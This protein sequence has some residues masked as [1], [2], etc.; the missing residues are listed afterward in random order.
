MTADP[1]A[2]AAKLTPA[3]RKALMQGRGHDATL[4]DLGNMGLLDEAELPALDE[5]PEALGTCTLS[6]LGLRV[7]AVLEARGDAN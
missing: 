7:R 6:P 5:G 4:F 3:Q 2:I 1:A